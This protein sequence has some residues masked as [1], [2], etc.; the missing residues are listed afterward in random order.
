M[1]VVL[2]KGKKRNFACDSI[3]WW[4]FTCDY[5]EDLWC[6]ADVYCIVKHIIYVKYSKKRYI[7]SRSV[8]C[9]N[10]IISLYC[11]DKNKSISKYSLFTYG[12]YFNFQVLCLGIVKYG[13]VSLSS[14]KLVRHLLF[15]SQTNR[16]TLF[17][18][19]IHSYNRWSCE[20]SKKTIVHTC[21]HY[22]IILTLLV[23]DML[24]LST[25]YDWVSRDIWL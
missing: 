17:I 12:G 1:F 19:N 2:F 20:R 24:Y 7:L 14:I 6:Y 9:E 18:H 13:R 22:E 21:F 4:L 5:V 8:E 16:Q 10:P 25:S 11:F 15:Y 23:V 3:A